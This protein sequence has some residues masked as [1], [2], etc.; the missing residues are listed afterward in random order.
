LGVPTSINF[1]VRIALCFFNQDE[2]CIALGIPSFLTFLPK[3]TNKSFSKYPIKTAVSLVIP[4]ISLD[5][6][7]VGGKEGRSACISLK[8]LGAKMF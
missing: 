3:D 4:S 2:N 7:Y 6:V 5:R 1:L 8:S